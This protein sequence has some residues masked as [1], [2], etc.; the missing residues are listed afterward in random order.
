MKGKKFQILDIYSDSFGIHIWMLSEDGRRFS[1]FRRFKPYFYMSDKKDAV[2]ILLRRFSRKID[3]KKTVKK[4]LIKGEIQVYKI[5]A[6]TPLIYLK[7]VSFIRKNRIFEDTEIYNIQL[8]PAQLFMYEKR[9]FPFCTVKP[10]ENNGKV[11]FKKIDSFENTDYSIFN[12]RI[13]RIKPDL[14]G[15]NPKQIKYLPPLYIEMEGEPGIVVDDG[16]LE[17]ISAILKKKI[18]I[19]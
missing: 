7:A 11:M 2:K 5:T 1:V 18:P 12:L 9:I 19:Y 16:N 3:I 17:Y 14:E 8:T 13:M 15:E 10:V 4:D 6:N